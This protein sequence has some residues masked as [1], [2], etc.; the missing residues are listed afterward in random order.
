MRKLEAEVFATKKHPIP[1]GG[2]DNASVRLVCLALLL[3]MMALVGRI[4][5]VW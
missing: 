1:S 2:A 5:S 4:V 3:A